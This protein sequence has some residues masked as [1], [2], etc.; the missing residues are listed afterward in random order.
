[1]GGETVFW[2]TKT[3]QLCHVAPCRG[4]ALLHAHGPL[5]ALARV[6]RLCTHRI[7]WLSHIM[8]QQLVE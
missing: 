8:I 1:V 2:K 5:I 6:I 3:K 4:S 7:A